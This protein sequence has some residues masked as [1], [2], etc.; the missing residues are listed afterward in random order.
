MPHP[1]RHGNAG[2]RPPAAKSRPLA[3]GRL[4]QTSGRPLQSV[5]TGGETSSYATIAEKLSISEGAVKVAAH[6]LRRRYRELLREE[7][8]QTVASPEEI[9]EEIR[10]LLSCL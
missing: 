8:A 10:Y 7:I 3:L 5:L 1:Q 2:G 9:E 4:P 6:R